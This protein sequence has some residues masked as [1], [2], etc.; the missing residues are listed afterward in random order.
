MRAIVIERHGNGAG[1][2]QGLLRDFDFGVVVFFCEYR[3]NRGDCQTQAATFSDPTRD[4]RK[5]LEVITQWRARRDQCGFA[6]V[7]AITRS[8]QIVC[9]GNAA[10]VRA[11]FEYCN[12]KVSI[13]LVEA[14]P[15]RELEETADLSVFLERCC[16][17][18]EQLARLRVSLMLICEVFSASDVASYSA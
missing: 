12:V 8:Q 6:P 3:V 4:E 7:L 9:Q 2:S 11:N 15:R 1:I 14:Y 5:A 17:I 10:P 16:V 18:N 13:G